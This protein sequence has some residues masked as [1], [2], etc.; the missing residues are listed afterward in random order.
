MKGPTVNCGICKRPLNQP[1]DPTTEDCGGDCLRCMADA[2]DPQAVAALLDNATMALA[3]P[4]PA[5]LPPLDYIGDVIDETVDYRE[6]GIPPIAE[7]PDPRPTV[8]ATILALA[9]PPYH[10]L[11]DVVSCFNARRGFYVAL[12]R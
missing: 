2:G 10:Q 7:L 9:D 8:M 1:D 3:P 6:R 12:S 11:K 5:V 4:A